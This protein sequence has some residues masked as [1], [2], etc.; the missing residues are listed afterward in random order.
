MMSDLEFKTTDE[1][2]GELEKRFD[3]MVFAGISIRRE[4]K[5]AQVYFY[6]GEDLRC[7][8]LC[9]NAQRF[10]MAAGAQTEVD[11]PEG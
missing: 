7:V 4:G 10:I 9:A 8:G 1:L 5:H 3:A 11:D 2:V 6:N